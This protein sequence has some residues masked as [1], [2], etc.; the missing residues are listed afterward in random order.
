MS[1]NTNGKISRRS[2]VRSI[3]AAGGMGFASGLSSGKKQSKEESI[4]RNKA[5]TILQKEKVERLLERVGDVSPKPNKA[6]KITSSSGVSAFVIRTRVGELFY[7]VQEGDTE[8]GITLGSTLSSGKDLNIP[9]D[10]KRKLN[11]PFDTL[12]YENP[13]THVIDREDNH[14]QTRVATRH[15]TEKI[16]DKIGQPSENL[17]PI[18]SSNLNNIVVVSK[19]SVGDSKG[20]NKY[21][22]KSVPEDASYDELDKNEVEELEIESNPVT[23]QNKCDQMLGDC[24]QANG[25]TAACISGCIM[26]GALTVG[27]AFAACAICTGGASFHAGTEC[28]QWYNNCV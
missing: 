27:L 19:N 12:S 23:I 18:I 16:A 1:D 17:I 6:K 9:V 26:G 2:I 8:A 3:G 14:I 4:S 13:V 21:L 15:E 25:A 10:Q 28:G 24:A 20:K 11:E 22:L 5:Q 7:G